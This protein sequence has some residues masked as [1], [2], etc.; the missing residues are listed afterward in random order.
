[1]EMPKSMGIL[2]T[3]PQH[4][5]HQVRINNFYTIAECTLCDTCYWSATLLKHGFHQRTISVCPICDNGNLS[6][7]PLEKNESYKLMIGPRRGLELEFS[8]RTVNRKSDV[9][10]RPG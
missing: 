7:I 3:Q 1:M 5:Q 4:P 9:H 2:R 8:K 6:F 10:P